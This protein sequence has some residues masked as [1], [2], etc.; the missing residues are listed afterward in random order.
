[1]TRVP[2]LKGGINGFEMETTPLGVLNS[3]LTTGAIRQRYAATL[4]APSTKTVS[5]SHLYQRS[6]EFELKRLF[7]L[8]SRDAPFEMCARSHCC[9]SGDLLTSAVEVV[10][11]ARICLYMRVLRLERR[12]VYPASAKRLEVPICPSRG[13][14]RT[15]LDLPR[16]I[17]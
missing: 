14:L 16:L 11:F 17:P 7:A 3:P 5:A 13:T 4:Q 6:T 9:P 2:K 1:M 10:A 12:G 8:G 15:V